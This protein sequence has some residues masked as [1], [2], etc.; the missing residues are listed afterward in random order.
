M[1]PENQF[2]RTQNTCL[3]SHFLD[4]TMLIMASIATTTVGQGLPFRCS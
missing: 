3:N 1:E 2:Y 4:S